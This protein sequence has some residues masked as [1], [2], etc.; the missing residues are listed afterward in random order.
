MKVN[1]IIAEYNPFHNGHKYHLDFS[2][3][4]TGADYTI[5]VMSGNFTQRGIPAI[6]DKKK[7]AKA[8][9]LSGADLVLEL[10]ACY[11]ASSA[12]YF[13][14]GGVSLL[15][16]LGV[17]DCLCF[18]SEC[19]DLSF[20]TQV[21]SILETEPPVYQSALRESLRQGNSFPK[22]RQE[23]LACCLADSVSFPVDN[24]ADTSFPNK[25]FAPFSLSD[26]QKAEPLATLRTEPNTLL[27]LE[28]LKALKRR[29][30]R[31]KP[32]PIKRIGEGYHSLS[33]D[34]SFCS[35]SALRNRI[36][37]SPVPVEDLHRDLSR[38]IPPE[39]LNCLVQDLQNAAPV[40]ADAFSSQLCYKL[41]C[42]EAAGF[43]D[44]ADVTQDLSD[45]IRK[46]LPEFQS[47]TSFC[48]L[49]KT[50]NLTYTR[51]SRSL[52]H[53]LLNQKASALQEYCSLDYIFYARVLG[54]RKD[55]QP[56]LTAIKAN[57][58]IPLV[59][60][61]ASAAVLTQPCAQSM[62][63]Q[64][65]LAAHIYHTA[66]HAD[67]LLSIPNEFRTPVVIC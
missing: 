49:L 53:I 50:K 47:F 25:S 5:V 20:L 31:I 52:T 9:L 1:G 8:A 23:A 11:A 2:K 29:K 44:Y 62:L 22:A 13:A 65:L 60:G 59:T 66:A 34:T 58:C 67:G 55:A 42:E 48:D 38:H 57:S 16:K 40:T 39:A 54:F 41:L 32:V 7:R 3:Q 51:I 30:S 36:G 61:A 6:I 21:A 43:T 27:A 45:R 10:P 24:H 63:A 64:D 26:E 33:L 46:M 12:E 28:Y 56:L 14:M 19:D 35:A 4:T 18:G 37:H 17:T 15:D